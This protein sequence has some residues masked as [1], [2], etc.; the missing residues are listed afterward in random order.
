MGMCL[1]CLGEYKLGLAPSARR[2]TYRG[3]IVVRYPAAT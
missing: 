1:V 3:G 2:R